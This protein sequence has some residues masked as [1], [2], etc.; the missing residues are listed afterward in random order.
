[1][2]L[3]RGLE[4]FGNLK[5]K[6]RSQFLVKCFVCS[7]MIVREGRAPGWVVGLSIFSAAIV[8]L[9]IER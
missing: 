4:P 7:G 1:M 8:R 3:S 5:T 2:G 6:K 9:W